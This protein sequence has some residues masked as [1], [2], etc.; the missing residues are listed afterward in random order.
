M[1]H[2]ARK[3]LLRLFDAPGQHDHAAVPGKSINDNRITLSR[4]NFELDQAPEIA[5]VID[6][7]DDF[8]QALARYQEALAAGPVLRARVRADADRTEVWAA[9]QR[10]LDAWQ[11]R[12]HQDFRVIEPVARLLTDF[13]LSLQAGAV[14]EATELLEAIRNRG[15]LSSERA[16]RSR[17]VLDDYCLA[18]RVGKFW[19]D[20]AA[21][22]I[23]P[24]A[25]RL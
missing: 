13:E 2:K 18:D 19:R 1:N 4:V 16:I 20:D 6:V 11:R 23:N 14:D 10:L 8:E 12:P 3:S 17:A 21:D 24:A 15:E 7:A 22:G 5:A 9:L 25:R